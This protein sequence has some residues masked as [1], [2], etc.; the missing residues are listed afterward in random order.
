MSTYVP[1][2]TPAL[3]DPLWLLRRLRPGT[4]PGALSRPRRDTETR[5]SGMDSGVPTARAVAQLEGA[6]ASS[7]AS[8][9]Q[10]P[11][12]RPLGVPAGNITS[13]GGRRSS[14]R[15]SASEYE[16]VD[17]EGELFDDEELMDEEDEEDDERMDE[18]ELDE[19]LSEEGGGDFL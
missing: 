17:D 8:I 7:M 4:N 19:G 9:S 16:T 5:A 12:P 11:A 2:V 6:L 1:A 13:A 14:R 15:Y 3:A 18:D 10:A